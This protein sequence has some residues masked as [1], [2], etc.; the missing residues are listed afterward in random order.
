QHNINIVLDQV[1]LDDEGIDST[2]PVSLRVHK[3]KLASALNL[4][5]H[6][7]HL[8]WTIRDEVLFLTN[9]DGSGD[10]LSVEIYDVRDL[11][12]VEG[13]DDG[14]EDAYDYEPLIGMIK[15]I[16]DPEMWGFALCGNCGAACDGSVTPLQGTLVIAQ[17]GPLHAEV[18]GLLARLRE[19]HRARETERRFRAAQLP[20]ALPA[21]GPVLRLYS[22]AHLIPP[23]ELVIE[24]SAPGAISMKTD[25]DGNSQPV[26]KPVPSRKVL[27]T[28]RFDNQEP[29]TQRVAEAIEAVVEPNTWE[30][31]GGSGI[32]R[33]V[34]GGVL[35][36]NEPRVHAR[37]QRL[38]RNWKPFQFDSFTKNDEEDDRWLN[39]AHVNGGGFGGGG[40]AGGGFFQLP[41][42]PPKETKQPENLGRQ[43]EEE[44]RSAP[45][46][47]ESKTT[48][49]PIALTPPTT[50]PAVRT[51]RLGM[52]PTPG[53]L[54]VERLQFA[55]TQPIKSPLG[56]T[57]L[58]SAVAAL[59]E[60]HGINIVINQA[61]LEGD[62]DAGEDGFDPDQGY[63][64]VNAS[65]ISLAA[66]LDLM[67]QP[68]GLTWTIR[69]ECV[70]I[71]SLDDLGEGMHAKFHDVND[72]LTPVGQVIP[73]SA[74]LD[75]RDLVGLVK[76]LVESDAWGSDG[77]MIKAFH[78]TLIVFQ[79]T[80]T[81]KGVERLLRQLRLV[82]AARQRDLRQGDP[83]LG[84]EPDA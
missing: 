78:G 18:R 71:T 31:N 67:L 73:Q 24:R 48:G 45:H 2:Q 54:A 32:L 75:E 65:G 80:S 42:E 40:G 70:V 19:V 38:I 50:K 49:S 60:R 63:V 66:A 62:E 82:R 3:V 23:R 72:L 15:N 44:D 25:K 79:T 9:F 34:P 1:A 6:P 47:N 7:I 11:V 33:A 12:G 35:V 20:E 5:L 59:K 27:R 43:K 46:K 77:G 53:E 37:I 52:K 68:T 36:R 39:Q 61:A 28:F 21:E 64:G 57:S 14:A 26:D 55:L 81:H 83:G 16:G 22:V 17:T 41:P 58:T 30:A 10:K 74:S 51:P 4:L 8:Q 13:M 84:D 69:N 56:L 76:G 29:F